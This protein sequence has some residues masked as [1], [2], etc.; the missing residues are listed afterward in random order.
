[1]AGS[2]A[3]AAIGP[4]V[5]RPTRSANGG[6]PRWQR[7]DGIRARWLWAAG[8]LGAALALGPALGPGSLL[9][10]DLVLTPRI[11][12]P[13]AVV[14]LGHELPRRVPLGAPLSWASDVVGGPT[15]GK[16]F[17]GAAITTA[18]VGAASL[19][20]R[21]PRSAPPFASLMA[22]ALYALGPFML[23]RVGAG[24]LAIVAT[25][26][27]LPFA[28]PHLVAPERD[29]SRTFLWLVAMGLT[30]VFGGLVGVAVAA[31]GWAF[32]S[33]RRLRSVP[34]FALG[35][36]L[37]Q[38]PW[39]VPGLL[40]RGRGLSLAPGDAFAT[41][42]E[43]PLGVVGGLLA[44]HGF[45]RGAS[46]VGGVAG[47]GLVALGVGL[48]L[49]AVVGTRDLPASWRRPLV[50]LGAL[51]LVAAAS[52]AVP[53]LDR[54]HAAATGTVAFAPLRDTQRLLA[55]FLLWAAPCAALG[56]TRL[57]R[58]RPESEALIWAAALAATTALI[59]PGLWGVEGRL[60]PVEFPAGWTR[61]EHVLRDEPGAVL[62]LPWH[63]YLNLGFADDRRVLNPMPDYLGGD[64][65]WSHDPELGRR[66]FQE[67]TDPREA[68]ATALV[69]AMTAGRPTGTALAD[70][71]VRWVVLVEEA[72]AADYGALRADP[73]LRLVVDDPAVTLYE[74]RGP[75]APPPPRGWGSR[76]ANVSLTLGADAL[77]LAAAS[78][79]W[80]RRRQSRAATDI[81]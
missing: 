6:R 53:G 47:P 57:V 12:F 66:R 77:V 33:N 65:V 80:T 26:A 28:L 45:W 39:L 61:V 81:A 36:A 4:A 19:T 74:V 27:V 3:L 1:M 18:F 16:L 5:D 62:A 37:A 9:S 41:S 40:L 69:E 58:A 32:G 43:G 44:Q 50:T 13:D 46:Q 79:A 23:T 24:H 75:I 67:G 78:F 72:D 20:R 22:G 56:V 51:G 25:V 35:A 49:L 38:L 15:A 71:G 17:L 14:G 34:A 42:S 30:G 55:L 29:P 73:G 31:T 11:P 7:V 70:L 8:V 48:A 76:P 54:L 52:P 64:V 21:G 63:E 2:G 60:R 10:L 59:V 68:E